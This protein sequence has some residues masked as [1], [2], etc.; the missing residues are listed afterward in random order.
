MKVQVTQEDIDNGNL[1]FCAVEHA[2]V[3]SFGTED[4]AV[5]LSFLSVNG[6]RYRLPDKAKSWIKKFDAKKPVKP[7][8]FTAEL[9]NLL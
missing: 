9:A 2:L 7:F 8:E 6:D 4:V 1:R 5:G 3:R